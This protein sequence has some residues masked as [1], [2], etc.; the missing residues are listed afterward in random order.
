[1]MDDYYLLGL[2]SVILSAVYL[3]TIYWEKIKAKINN[4]T[5]INKIKDIKNWKIGI[6]GIIRLFLII[7]IL[8]SI[9]RI[10]VVLYDQLEHPI[11]PD[12]EFIGHLNITPLTNTTVIL[13]KS[14]SED[15]K[16]DTYNITYEGIN[17]N[18]FSFNLSIDEEAFAYIVKSGSPIKE[19]QT[20]TT[21]TT[22]ENMNKIIQAQ[23]Q[24]FN[25]SIIIHRQFKSEQKKDYLQ[26]LF[27]FLSLD[28]I[29]S[30]IGRILFL[31]ILINIYSL[32]PY[33]VEN[34]K[35]EKNDKKDGFIKISRSL[36]LTS[37]ILALILTLTPQ[38]DIGT[39]KLNISLGDAVAAFLIIISF[40]LAYL[41]MDED[42]MD[43]F[44]DRLKGMK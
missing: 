24:Y 32:V 6:V 2:I 37:L 44:K 39:I 35:Q 28:F 21:S 19:G 43:R 25:N 42:I 20:F 10:G 33:L 29:R 7:L 15:F 26:N 4:I 17:K 41:F 12:Q 13:N 5:Y 3:V 31:I 27:S 38:G 34:D 16:T 9:G 22:N 36:I 8:T 30:E 23:G 14:L 40:I 18:N 1:M 11:P